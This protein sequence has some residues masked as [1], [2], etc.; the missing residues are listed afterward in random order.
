VYVPLEDSVSSTESNVKMKDSW[1]WAAWNTVLGTYVDALVIPARTKILSV[2]EPFSSGWIPAMVGIPNDF[3]TLYMLY[4]E[5]AREAAK[6]SPSSLSL[7]KVLAPS[8][9]VDPVQIKL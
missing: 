7:G 5:S 4:L 2:L 3:A 6:A 8:R 1:P 9:G